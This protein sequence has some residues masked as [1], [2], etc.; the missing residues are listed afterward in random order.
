VS[1]GLVGFLGSRGRYRG[2]GGIIMSRRK[3]RPRQPP[4]ERIIPGVSWPHRMSCIIMAAREI[5]ALRKRIEPMKERYVRTRDEKPIMD[6]IHNILGK[7]WKPS[8]HWATTIA[9]TTE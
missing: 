5:T 4:A 3:Q 6:A 1:A 7:D 8:G 9:E 2:V